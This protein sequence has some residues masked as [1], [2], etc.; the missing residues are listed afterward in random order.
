MRGVWQATSVQAAEYSCRSVVSPDSQLTYSSDPSVDASLNPG[1]TVTVE[2]TVSGATDLRS[3]YS[4]LWLSLCNEESNGALSC[5]DPNSLI[6]RSEWRE[7][8]IGASDIGS[9][10]AAARLTTDNLDT[11]GSRYKITL[12][13]QTLDG[14]RKELCSAKD[15][16][17]RIT[18][19]NSAEDLYETNREQGNLDE[20]RYCDQISDLAER[21]KCATCI[22]NA[23]ADTTER[24]YTAFGCIRIDN[25][26]LA[27]DIITLMIGISGTIA[28][29]IILVAAFILSISQGEMKHVKQAKDLITAAVSGLFFI[30]FSI[31]ILEFVGVTILR[32]PGLG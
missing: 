6:G 15:D 4:V 12:L 28:L 2:F 5:G 9:K 22:G 7:I 14:Q 21:Q 27:S 30:I 11:D 32:I 23:D 20:F 17:I 24:L 29:L 1:D 8:Q 19:V 3:Q 18:R 10:T 13:G 31:I 16:A 26:G 25:A